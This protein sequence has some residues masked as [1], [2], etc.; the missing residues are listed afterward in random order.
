MD[1]YHFSKCSRSSLTCTA[2]SAT[3][4][5]QGP[6]LGFCST[7]VP[8]ALLLFST[9]HPLGSPLSIFSSSFTLNFRCQ[10]QMSAW[11][12]HLGFSQHHILNT[13]TLT[14]SSVLDPAFQQGE[15]RDWSSG[16]AE[17]KQRGWLEETQCVE[18][19][20]HGQTFVFVVHSDFYHSIVQL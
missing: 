14:F 17:D 13:F 1:Q 15:V 5:W 20:G 8:Y 16:Q 7:T 11:Y 3:V 10:I 19:C 9:H 6:E 2:C 18:E 4:M 12:L